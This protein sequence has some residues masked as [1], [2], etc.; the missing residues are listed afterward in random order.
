MTLNSWQ[1]LVPWH[2]YS[3]LWICVRLASH[4]PPLNLPLPIPLQSDVLNSSAFLEMT[5]LTVNRA[6]SHGQPLESSG[7]QGTSSLNEVS[8]QATSDQPCGVPDGQEIPEKTEDIQSPVVQQE[9]TADPVGC[10]TDLTVPGNCVPQANEKSVLTKEAH[11]HEN[12]EVALQDTEIPDGMISGEKLEAV[13]HSSPHDSKDSG[14]E[15]TPV[16]TE[17]GKPAS[18]NEAAVEEPKGDRNETFPGDLKFD[19]ATLNETLDKTEPV[20]IPSLVIQSK[21]I[22]KCEDSRLSTQPMSG[23][24]IYWKTHSSHLVVLI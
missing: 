3:H 5:V 16:T 9:A 4:C 24:L 20:S 6:V 19:E 8:I 17:D 11:V 7:S 22:S 18:G 2:D 14:L 1:H 23:L 15:D 21:G 12:K 13:A 10:S